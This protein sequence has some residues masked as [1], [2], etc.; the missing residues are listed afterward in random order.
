L[1]LRATYHSK[2]L[3][4]T[5][6]SRRDG[7]GRGIRR[8]HPSG[9]HIGVSTGSRSPMGI[10]ARRNCRPVSTTIISRP[11][12]RTGRS[13]S[14]PRCSRLGGP[15]AVCGAA[16]G[17][18]RRRCAAGAGMTCGVA[19][20]GVLSVG[21]AS[22]RQMVRQPHQRPAV[23]QPIAPAE[24]P[25]RTTIMHARNRYGA[26]RAAK[27][28][29]LPIAACLSLV[30]AIAMSALWVRGYWVWEGG[31]SKSLGHVSASRNR[32]TDTA[33]SLGGG[34][35]VLSRYVTFEDS[36]GDGSVPKGWVWS[37]DPPPTRVGPRTWRDY[38]FS[39]HYWHSGPPQLPVGEYFYNFQAVIP[40]WSIVLA[41]ALL[42]AWWG[43]RRLRR[44]RIPGAPPVC[45]RCGYD[46]RGGHD[47]CPECGE[48]TPGADDS[49]RSGVAA[50]DVAATQSLKVH[51]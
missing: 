3:P 14:L 8:P 38:S 23:P 42:P 40:D 44:R 35:I 25:I 47:R 6:G 24:S 17:R 22:F 19:M 16:A 1:S 34:Y 5:V 11:S 27:I 49:K 20:I 26:Q 39:Y 45:S 48:P 12:S 41:S 4:T 15:S 32:Y 9:G 2:T 43:V 33:I 50:K 37:R 18:V 7:F 46:L 21:R 10:L 31:E 51:S 30:T 36:A 28:R 13:C 29:L